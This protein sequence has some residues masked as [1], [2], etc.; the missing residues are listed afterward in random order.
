MKNGLI[1]KP[2]QE[3]YLHMHLLVP[4]KSI[5]FHFMRFVMKTD[6]IYIEIRGQNN[7]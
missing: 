2:S 5:I 7:K 3:L 1:Q 6:V 4:G